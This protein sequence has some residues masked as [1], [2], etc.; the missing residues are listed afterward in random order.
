MGEELKSNGLEIIGGT[1]ADSESD[2]KYEMIKDYKFDEDVGAV[3]CGIDFN[4]NY[5]KITLA[6]MY[7]QRGAKW[8]VCNDDAFTMQ[9][10]YRAPGNGMTIAAIESGLKTAD[11]KGLICEK[12]VTGKPNPAIIDLIRGQHKID[13]DLKKMVMIGDRPNT[14]IS[15]GNLSGIDSCLVLTG[16]VTKESEIEDWVGQDPSYA[17]TWVLDSFGEDIG[18]TDEEKSK[19]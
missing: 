1:K 8:I 12:I 6:S 11:G 13:C 2:F 3:V 17:P 7:L 9:S 10:G 14:D 19:I 5:R 15:L 4:V 18:L 16:V